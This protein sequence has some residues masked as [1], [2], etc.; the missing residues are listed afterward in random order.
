MLAGAC[1]AGNYALG[2]ALDLIRLGRADACSP[3]EPTRSRASPSRA[4]PGLGALAAER[5]PAVQRTIAT[6]SS[7]ARELAMLVRRVATAAAPR[8]APSRSR[9]SAGIGLSG[10]AFHIVSPDPAGRG[11]ARAMEAALEDAGVDRGEIGYLSAHGTGTP[12]NDRAEVAA[13]RAVFGRSGPADE[14]DQG[15]H[16]SRARSGER[17]RGCRLRAGAARTQIAPPTWNFTASRSGLR[18]GRDPERAARAGAR[19]RPQQ[20][21]RLRRRQ[22]VA[23]PAGGG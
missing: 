14:L 12:A 11:A 5:V 6:G 1:A 9:S 15:D 7:S 21:L 3:A 4:S 13:A 2:H 18:L 8:A 20:R 23:R 16:R 22:R 17:A 19:R 10:D